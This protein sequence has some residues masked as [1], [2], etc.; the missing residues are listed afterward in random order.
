VNVTETVAVRSRRAL[1]AGGASAA[2]AAALAGCG[3]KALR[4]RIRSGAHV[5]RTDVDG[6]NALLDVENHGIAAYAA[7]IPLLNAG[8][9]LIGKQFLSQELAHAVELSD[10]VKGAGGKPHK[11][12][13]TYDLGNPRTEAEAF[14]LLENAERL[15]LDAY[16]QMI[17]T[18]SGG[19]VRAAI[20]TIFAN[21]AQHLAV[22]RLQAGK[23]LPGAFAVA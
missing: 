7:G 19:R 14:A 21:D 5:S 9:Q 6:L 12:P 17:P 15:Q 8:A 2:G 4:E 11:R 23:P 16:L 3:G 1:L 13:A 10:L 20:A 22:V 18:L